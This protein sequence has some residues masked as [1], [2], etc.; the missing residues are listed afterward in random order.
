[1]VCSRADPSVLDPFRFR[2]AAGTRTTARQLRQ[3]VFVVASVSKLSPQRLQVMMVM[4][5][6]IAPSAARIERLLSVSVAAICPRRHTER[7]PHAGAW[8]DVRV[9]W[10]FQLVVLLPANRRLNGETRQTWSLAEPVGDVSLSAAGEALQDAGEITFRGSGYATEGAAQSAGECFRDWVRVASALS[11]LGFDVGRDSRR[12]SWLGAEVE[13]NL[14]REGQL[15][16]DDV[17]GLVVFE[18]H[19]EPFRL[20]A[21][22]GG[23]VVQQSSIAYE[24]VLAIASGSALTDEQSLA[25]D[26]VSL[27]E[28]EGSDRTRFLILVT[29][30]EVLAERQ[31][32]AGALRALVERLIVEAEHS[33]NA[34]GP[35]EKGRYSSLVGG[36][37]ELLSESIAS[38]IRDL[39]ALS[40][41]DDSDVRRLANRIY[42]CRSDLVHEGRST[43][44]PRDLLGTTQELVR[45]MI[46]HT[47]SH[48]AEPERD[49]E[50]GGGTA[51]S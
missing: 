50:P 42:T 2:A 40:R 4:A 51:E 9:T 28:H 31:E 49:G 10:G 18:E 23:T 12:L 32:R 22:A 19:G 26:L 29:A 3:R 36:L 30:M 39:A 11:G 13:A 35:D 33:R 6:I 20:T 45:D 27:A 17:H 46:R 1:M 16:V 34:A 44:D 37:R 7:T 21:R 14:R 41:P 43:E 8:H 48:G 15:L 38:S 24:N 25:C 5:P 47:L